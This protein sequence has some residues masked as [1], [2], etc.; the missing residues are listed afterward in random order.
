ML[1]VFEGNT[2]SY[3]VKHSYLDQPVVAR[4]IKF[5]TVHWNKHPSMRVEII[6]CQGMGIV[7]LILIYP[8]RTLVGAQGHRLTS[9]IRTTFSC[10]PCRPPETPSQLVLLCLR[11]PSQCCPWSSS[12]PLTLTGPDSVMVFHVVCRLSRV[13]VRSISIF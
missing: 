11:S 13:C 10:V 2:D 12:S 9:A 5:H 3:S 8:L 6:G 7:T 1:Q 4:F